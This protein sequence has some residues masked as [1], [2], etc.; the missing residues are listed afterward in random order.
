MG[1]GPTQSPAS[2]G[3]DERSRLGGLQPVLGTR[4]TLDGDIAF[5]LISNNQPTGK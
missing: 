1:H 3:I 5:S 4:E 2:D